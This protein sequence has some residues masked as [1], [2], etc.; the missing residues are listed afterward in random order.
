MRLGYLLN[1]YPRRSTTFITREIQA[2]ESLGLTIHRFAMRPEAEGAALWPDEAT[3]TEYLWPPHPRLILSPAIHRPHIAMAMR[4][5]LSLA[6]AA[7]DTGHAPPS[8][9]EDHVPYPRPRGAAGHL[10]YLAEAAA[11]CTRAR[12]LGLRHIHAHFGTNAATVALLAA[13][14]SGGRLSFSMTIHGPEEFAIAK[15]LSL[16]QKV[17]AAAFTR[18]ISADGAARIRAIVAPDDRPPP[19]RPATRILIIPCPLPTQSLA[20]PR[21]LPDGPFTLAFVGRLVTQKGADRLGQCA[22]HRL[23]VAGDGPLDP[24]QGAVRVG[25]QSEAGV[26]RVLDAAHALILPSRDEGLPLAVIEAMAAGRPVIATPVGAIRERVD[27]DTGWICDPRH[28]AQTIA[29]AA[30]SPLDRLAAMG[31]AGR[32]RVLPH[33]AP[34]TVARQLAACFAPYLVA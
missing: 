32:Q 16:T 9:S 21:P 1:T 4:Q 12:A 23:L 27:R 25:W 28:L 6:K 30:A 24:P 10:A 15:A 29:T 18:C 20:P 22:P 33:H 31:R 11:L 17:Q 7:R 14:L 2:L 8:L 19:P 13:T 26:R 5:A 3:R 34:E